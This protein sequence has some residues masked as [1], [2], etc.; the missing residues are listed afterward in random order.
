M[1]QLAAKQETFC[2][3][4]GTTGIKISNLQLEVEE[5][6]DDL[7]FEI[8]ITTHTLSCSAYEHLAALFT[9][10][11][12]PGPITFLLGLAYK[13]LALASSASRGSLCQALERHHILSTF[14]GKVFDLG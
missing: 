9:P 4:S 1:N 13:Q 7:E 14:V 2:I 10:R 3:L 5:L 8:D 12:C 11:S 6:P